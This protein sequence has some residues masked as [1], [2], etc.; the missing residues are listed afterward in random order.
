M[1]K[2]IAILVGVLL[3][4]AGSIW[5]IGAVAPP[6]FGV[7]A[8]NEP[9]TC[10]WTFDISDG[11]AMTI[12][13]FAVDVDVIAYDGDTLY[14]RFEGTRGVS[15]ND[16]E[17]QASTTQNNILF[18][19]TYP[20]GGRFFSGFS[21]MR[22]K[23]TIKVPSVT[24]SRIEARNT[25]GKMSIRDMVC[26]GEFHANASS[27]SIEVSNIRAATAVLGVSS[28]EITASG[29][30]A[31]TMKTTTSSGGIA[32]NNAAVSGSLSS[33]SS[34][35]SIRYTSVAADTA[36]IHSSSGTL[37][38]SGIAVRSLSTDTSSGSCTA[39]LTQSADVA[40]GSSSGSIRLGLPADMGF[41][42]NVDT[43]SGNVALGFPSANTQSSSKGITSAAVGDGA[44][45]VRIHTSSGSVTIQ[46]AN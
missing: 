24:L 38:L 14:A 13:V 22:G 16:A 31:G 15:S 37:D 11:A 30:T 9:Y 42:C 8:R 20:A 29:I 28:G 34:S 43:S 7:M 21:Q 45:A 2:S 46:P 10:E 27:G 39:M 23:L 6:L 4:F 36:D 19:E 44:H 25:S 40:C 1:P 3:I 17:I 41:T 12:D 35:G 5:L 33:T 18:K 26:S 32:L